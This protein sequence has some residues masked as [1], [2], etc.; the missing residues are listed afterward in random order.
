MRPEPDAP[1]EFTPTEPETPRTNTDLPASGPRS[2]TKPYR[3][4]YYPMFGVRSPGPAAP[5]RENALFSRPCALGRP[6]PT[7]KV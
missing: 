1:R 4:G 6:L 2:G 3:G 5:A 7:P